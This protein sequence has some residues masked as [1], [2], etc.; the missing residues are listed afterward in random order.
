MT[1][2]RD[3][4]ILQ[5]DYTLEQTLAIIDER[6]FSNYLLVDHAKDETIGVVSVKD[7]ILKTGSDQPFNLADIAGTSLY[8]RKFVCQENIGAI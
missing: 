8:T 7:I 5:P 3:L 4:V 6:H 2:R 1:H